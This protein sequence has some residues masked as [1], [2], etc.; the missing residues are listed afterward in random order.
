MRPAR[1]FAAALALAAVA[2]PPVFA[3]KSASPTAQKYHVTFAFP[4]DA[5]Y[6]GSMTLSIRQG[7]VSGKMAIDAPQAVTGDVAGTLKGAAL[8]LDYPYEVQ[9]DQPCTGR[10]TVSATFN[11]ARTEAKGTTH[12]EGCGSPQDGTFTMTKDK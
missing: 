1:P 2:T 3:Q 12:S 5:T 4:D 9:G 11:A 7:K 10:V 8:A 6:T